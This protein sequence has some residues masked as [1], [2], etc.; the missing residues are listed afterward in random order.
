MAFLDYITVLVVRFPN[1]AVMTKKLFRA[2]NG[3]IGKTD[4]DNASHFNVQKIGI[5]H[6]A[7][8]CDVLFD[9]ATKP[10]RVAIRGLPIDGHYNVRRRLHGDKAA[11]VADPRGHHWLMADFDEVQLPLFLEPDDEPELLLLYLVRMLPAEFHH[12]TFYWQWSC[13]QG[14]DGGKTLRAHLFYWSR[15]EHT[16]R[17]YENWANWINGE[18]GWKVIDPAVFRTVQPNYTAAPK[19]GEGVT[20]PVRGSRNGIHIGETIDVPITMP[21]QDWEQHVREQE[22]EEYEELVEYRSAPTIHA[23]RVRG[24]AKFGAVP[25]LP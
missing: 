14:L 4:Y 12:A 16:D 23:G 7:D 18:A 15:E 24:A 21:T 10:D 11:F 1:D 19:L 9:L 6:L 5:N 17:E 20:D 22:R 8:L 25:L 2:T 13:G 3:A